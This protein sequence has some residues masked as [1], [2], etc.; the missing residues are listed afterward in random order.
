M[1]EGKEDLIGLPIY[2]A[3]WPNGNARPPQRTWVGLTEEDMPDGENPMFDH[4]YF[5]A[6]MV[7][8]TKILEKKNTSQ[9]P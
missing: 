4:K 7:F 1:V 8:A 6:G 2:F 9:Q 5:I 3:Q